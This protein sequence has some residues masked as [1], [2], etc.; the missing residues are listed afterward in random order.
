M[1]ACHGL[2]PLAQLASSRMPPASV[3]TRPIAEDW[4]PAGVEAQMATDDLQSTCSVLRIA[5]YSDGKTVF[6]S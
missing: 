4:A 2:D 1:S 6:Q 3:R 5:D